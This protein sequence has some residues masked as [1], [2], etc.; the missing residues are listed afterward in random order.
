MNSEKSSGE[1]TQAEHRGLIVSIIGAG[2]MA[3]LGFGFAFLTGSAVILLDGVFST[4]SVVLALLSLQVAKIVRYPDDEHFQFGYAHFEP[5]LNVIKGLLMLLLCIYASAA[6]IE[7][8]SSG[9]R[10][11][12]MGTAVFYG[13]GATAGGFLITM[14]LRHYARTSGSALVEVDAKSATMDAFLSAAV[15][16]AFIIA[17]KVEGT[18]ADKYLPYLDPG[19]VVFFSLVILPLPLKILSVNLRELLLAAPEKDVQADITARFDAVTQ[20]YGFD[21]RLLRMLRFGRQTSVL[22][23]VI[24]SQNFRLSSIT[25]LDAI[26]H[27]VNQELSAHYP[28]IFCDIIFINDPALAGPWKT[29]DPT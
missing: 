22:A 20:E 10:E 15:L 4:I 7:A 16:A 29:S 13:A 14:V 6:A 17:W 19:L 8:I 21:D 23:H 3:V 26:R 25:D 28:G 12:P 27:R 5:L 24:C 18:A 2:F 9:G 11:L 1:R